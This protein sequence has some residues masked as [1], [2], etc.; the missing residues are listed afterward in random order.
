MNKI[1][2]TSCLA[3]TLAFA[4]G[5]FYYLSGA[6]VSRATSQSDPPPEARILGLLDVS[7]NDA[8]A[9]PASVRAGEDFQLKI[10]T[11]G[12]GCERE[13]DTGVILMD[14]SATVMVYDFTTATRPGVACTM[15]F[16][17]L[18]HTV[19]LRFSKPGT[20]IIRVWGRKVGYDTPPMGVPTVLERSVTVR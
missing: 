5:F 15:I 20:A 19:N 12:S 13:G 8:L 14:D 9:A 17:R 11:T 2:R 4:T 7:G 10:T 3:L 6:V 1:I 16:K 18:N